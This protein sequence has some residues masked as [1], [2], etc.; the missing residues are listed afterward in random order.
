MKR[1]WLYIFLVIAALM[2]LSLLGGVEWMESTYLWIARFENEMRGIDGI[3]EASRVKVLADANRHFKVYE[4]ICYVVVALAGAAI[5]AT[6]WPA[7][8][9]K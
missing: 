4:I 9:G 6:D 8:S 3:T 5:W 7:K 1:L 2:L